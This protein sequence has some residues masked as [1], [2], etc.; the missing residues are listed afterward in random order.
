MTFKE[1]Y[2]DFRLNNSLI[3]RLEEPENCPAS[4]Y[5][6]FVTREVESEP[7]LA[8]TKGVYF[9]SMTLG[10]GVGGKVVDD[11]PRL[12]NGNK[13]TDHK[14]IDL[15]IGAFKRMFDPN[16]EEYM[17]LKIVS[18][19]ETLDNGSE[20]GT[21]DFV[22]ES[23]D[24]WK[25]GAGK[26]YIA[27]LKLT[28]DIMAKHQWSWAKPKEKDLNQQYHYE[29]LWMDE[30][31]DHFDGSLVFVF[32]YTDNLRRMVIEVGN[33][34]EKRQEARERASAAWGVLDYYHEN[35]HYPE[36]PSVR[37]CSMCPVHTCSVRR[38]KSDIRFVKV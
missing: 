16:D 3:Q 29:N 17:G 24:K 38:E 33:D 7:T 35:G 37:A 1:A 30:G 4:L 12:K 22:V 23:D 28:G 15:Q 25:Y 32:D 34:P 13:T 20:K 27:D 2:P 11:L 31:R 10:S 21:Y 6:L 5:Q 18:K 36:S 19:D 8:M 14:R 26:R 9:E